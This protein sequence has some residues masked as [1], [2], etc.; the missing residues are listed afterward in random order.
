MCLFEL[1]FSQG[2]K[3]PVILPEEGL[4]SLARAPLQALDRVQLHQPTV[5]KA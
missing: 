1:W 4:S 5:H 2:L 3:I